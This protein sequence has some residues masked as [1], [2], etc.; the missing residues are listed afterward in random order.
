MEFTAADRESS[1]WKKL[2]A[3]YRDR[4]TNL[5]EQ[6]D[7]TMSDEKRNLLIGRIQEV[8]AFLALEKPVVVIPKS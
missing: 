1:L 4:L 7:S 6:N 8:K 5:R 2:T 3:H